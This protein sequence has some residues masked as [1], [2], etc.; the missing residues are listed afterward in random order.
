MD[1]RE[2]PAGADQVIT[3]F[4]TDDRSAQL[5]ADEIFMAIAADAAERDQQGWRAVSMT[6]LPLRQTGT[7]GNVLFQSG[8][9]FAT[10]AAVAVLYAR[11]GM[12]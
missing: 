9:Q 1:K 11:D 4:V 10:M 7:T 3:V 5:D 6:A 2:Y 12:G 8:G